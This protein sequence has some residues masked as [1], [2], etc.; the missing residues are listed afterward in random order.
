[1]IE[2]PS[3]TWELLREFL[4]ASISSHLHPHHEGGMQPSIALLIVALSVA[5]PG[6]APAQAP[7]RIELPRTSLTPDDVAVV[8]NDSDTLSRRIGDY[9]QKRRRIPAANMIHVRFEPGQSSISKEDFLEIKETIDRNTPAHVQAYAVAWTAPYRV[10]CMSLTSALAFGFNE[11]YCSS[12]CEPTAASG[13]YNSTTLYPA[14]DQ[15]LRP[16]MMLAG[17]NFEQVKTL[18]DRGVSSDRSFPQGHAYLVITPD[19]MRSVRFIHFEQTAKAFAG[20]FPV[21]ILEVDALS[22]RHDVLFYFTGS[23]SVPLL[24]TLDFLP[25]ALADHLTSSGGQLTDS[26]QM[27]SLRWLEAGATASYGTVVEPCNHVQKFPAP[28]VAMFYYAL[29]A[30]AIEAYWKSVAWPGEG[31]FVGEPLAQPFAPRLRE[32]EAGRYELQIFSPRE[33][34]LRIER[35]RSAA[36]PFKP[37]ARQTL[38][39]RGVNIVRFNFAETDGYLRLRW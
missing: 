29:G 30:S 36:G 6:T 7:G 27:S 37:L 17:I 4:T 16:A 9:Y 10:D 3:P 11:R 24:D 5:W 23:E 20:V 34:R 1:M 18:I 19:K 13:Y 38:L 12:R 22:D 35:S 32:V 26:N 33:K 8:I 14:R 15:G 31:V 2:R 28:G 25:G 21:E 39:R